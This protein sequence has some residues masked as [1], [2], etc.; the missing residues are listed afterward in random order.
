MNRA[1]KRQKTS[2]GSTSPATRRLSSPADRR[3]PKAPVITLD[4]LDANVQ[5][6]S[7]ATLPSTSPRAITTGRPAVLQTPRIPRGRVPVPSVKALETPKAPAPPSSP[8]VSASNRLTNVDFAMQ[9]PPAKGPVSRP[10][11]QPSPSRPAEPSTS[12][13]RPVEPSASP[14][15]KP[16]A[17]S[18]RLS[19]G[20]KRGTLMICQPLPPL[21]NERKTAADNRTAVKPARARRTPVENDM[22]NLD[23]DQ[24][25]M[26]GI[27]DQTL[28]IP[29]TPPPA[30]QPIL[31]PDSPEQLL[32]KPKAARTV[33]PTRDASPQRTNEPVKPRSPPRTSSANR[34]SARKQPQPPIVRKSS[35]TA[36]GVSKAAQAAAREASPALSAVSESRPRTTSLSPCKVAALSTGGFRKSVKCATPQASP[37]PEAPAPRN[38]AAALPPHPLRANRKGPVMTT[39]ELAAMLQKPKKKPKAPADPIEQGDDAAATSPNRKFRRVRSENDAPIPSTSEDWEQRN[40]P[41]PDTPATVSAATASVTIFES[42][43]EPRETPAAVARKKSGLAALIKKTDP[44]KKF[45]RTQ[46]LTVET[47]LPPPAAIESPLVSPTVDK[48]VGPW[49]TEAGDLFDWRPPGRDSVDT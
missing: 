25:V 36:T 28:L 3:P 26:H 46:S 23:A 13:P 38:E 7:E 12:P 24:E 31:V 32:P 43:A 6:S 1:A 2:H 41:K 27:M 29:S 18:L 45:I 5:E 19:K 20:V 22:T 48:D 10:P 49:S 21:K 11:Q 17:K 44:R 8:P 33:R 42:A 30:D 14:P 37:A 34:D 39:T 9:P 4:E 40:L 16:K 47:S 15:R 35:P